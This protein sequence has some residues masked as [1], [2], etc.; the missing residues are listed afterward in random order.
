MRR[1]GLVENGEHRNNHLRGGVF[2]FMADVFCS[3]ASADTELV[4][5]CRETIEAAGFTHFFAELEMEGKSLPDKIRDNIRNSK[6]VIVLWTRN[7]NDVPRTRDMVNTEIGQAH[8]ASK[9][10]YAF[11]EKGAEVPLFLSNIT[12]Y[13][14][15]EPHAYHVVAER[16]E[17]VLNKLKK[18]NRTSMIE[19]L[20]DGIIEVENNEPLIFALSKGDIVE[21]VMKE[22]D[23]YD[24]N[25]YIMS[26]RNYAKSQ[27]DREDGVPEREF[28]DS[29]SYPVKWK[30]QRSG[31]WYFDFDNYGKQLDRTIEVKL[32]RTRARNDS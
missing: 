8:M 5:I 23:G 17:G 14:V 3:H 1:V 27:G 19:D 2:P 18:E 28:L 20:Y 22:T 13:S 15:F 16:L 26:E 24:F 31:I 25:C 10:V 4:S 30:V 11:R 32:R 29:S 12:D 7:V 9:S 6:I 21:G